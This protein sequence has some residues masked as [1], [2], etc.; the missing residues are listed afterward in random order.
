MKNRFFSGTLGFVLVFGLIIYGCPTDSGGGGGN[1][2]KF[3]GT[4]VNSGETWELIYRFTENKVDYSDH[5]DLRWSGTFTFTDTTITFS[6]SPSNSWIQ[7]YT[8][9]EDVLEISNTGGSNP[10]GTFVKQK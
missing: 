6:T 7:G 2:A 1:V 8:L 10:Y 5:T 4:W 9:E 3:E